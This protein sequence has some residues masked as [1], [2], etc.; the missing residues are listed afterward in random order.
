MIWPLPEIHFSENVD[1]AQR[2]LV[3]HVKNKN[4]SLESESESECRF[5]RAYLAL[6]RAFSAS[7]YNRAI[8]CQ[9][10]GDHPIRLRNL[11][12]IP[13]TTNTTIHACL[14]ALLA[15]AAAANGLG[16]LSAPRIHR[17]VLNGSLFRS[18]VNVLYIVEP[19]GTSGPPQSSSLPTL[20][21]RMLVK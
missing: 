6:P 2:W 4:P 11:A 14:A 15:L 20:A 16:P 19:D 12:S 17:R 21:I 1:E 18:Y 9:S 3:F 8:L 5:A 13:S 10:N 7:I